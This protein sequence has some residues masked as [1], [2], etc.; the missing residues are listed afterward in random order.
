MRRRARRRRRSKGRRVL[1]IFLASLALLILT[2]AVVGFLAGGSGF[3][4]LFSGELPSLTTLKEYK[5]PLVTRV[6]ADDGSVIGE[7]YVEKRVWVPY[8]KIPAKLIFAFVSAED[9]RFF[10]HR[11]L[12]YLGI[13]RAAIKNI[14]AGAFIQGGST[15]TQ[16]VAKMILL[17]PERSI[18]RKVKE[19]ITALRIERHFTKEQ[20]LELYLNQIY[21]GHGAYGVAQA[22]A[23]YFNKELE[24]LKLAEMAILAGLPRAPTRYSPTNNPEKAKERQRYVLRRMVEE[25]HITR[26]QARAILHTKIRLAAA[27][28]GQMDKASYFVEHVRRYLEKRYGTDALYKGGLSVRTTLNI[29]LQEASVA[30]LKQGLRRLDK[31]QGFRGPLKRIS[32]K[33]LKKY[34]T[35]LPDP[36]VE[37]K[38]LVEDQITTGVVV[39]LDRVEPVAWVRLKGHQGRMDLTFANRNI[40]LSPGD[41]VQVKVER[42]DPKTKLVYLSLEQEPLA[43]GAIIAMNPHSGFVKAMVGGSDFRRSE[44]NRAIQSRRQP[45][46]AFKPVIYAAAL[47]AGY[48]PTSILMDEPASYP[49]SR[50]GELWEPHNYDN[51]YKGPITLRTALA[52]S[53]NV[54]TVRLLDAIGIDYVIKYARRLG[55]TSP[56]DPYLSLALGTSGLSLLELTRAYAS[57][58]AQ[59]YLTEP[60]FVIQVRDRNNKVLEENAPQLTRVMSPE[61]AYLMVSLMESVIQEGTGRSLRSLRR[62]AAG[63]TGT[64]DDFVDAWFIGYTPQLVAGVWVGFDDRRKLGKKE[65][66]ARAAAP[67]WLKFMQSALVN[68]PVLPFKIPEEIVMIPVD[69]ETGQPATWESTDTVLQPFR[70]RQSADSG[71]D[72][73][74]APFDPATRLD[75][76]PFRGDEAE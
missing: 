11:G 16:Q 67:I 68:E 32:L 37:G 65:S 34:L 48:T 53:R 30:A 21:L 10:K 46:S 50:R 45:G 52:E 39:K 57:F 69:R 49:G 31:R 9:S 47:D 1:R 44:F 27:D 41:V 55:I 42:N 72:S 7:F 6:Y 58:A 13:M 62:P 43:Q 4:F 75:L 26:N 12:D 35:T 17:T 22:A 40:P 74:P 2:L 19:M 51:K 61:T 63:K 8:D 71:R 56:L 29:H 14:R 73:L 18:N 33:R 76:P 28:R 66:G 70:A 3:S 25:G 59:G 20:I 15:I 64:T 38:K 24:E 23:T 60:I 36:I 5:P 54:A